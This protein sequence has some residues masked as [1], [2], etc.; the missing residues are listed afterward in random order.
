MN[1]PFGN[2]EA[3]HNAACDQMKCRHCN[4]YHFNPFSGIPYDCQG[5]SKAEW[6]AQFEAFRPTW[7]AMNKG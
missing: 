3:E 2:T 5:K 7:E 4:G 1:Y 6:D